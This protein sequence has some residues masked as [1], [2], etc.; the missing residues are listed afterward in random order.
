MV[1]QTRKEMTR[2]VGK[3]YTLGVEQ[4]LRLRPAVCGMN[5]SKQDVFVI[6]QTKLT[7]KNFFHFDD[8]FTGF[9]YFF[10]RR[11]NPGPFLK[12]HFIGK[13][14]SLAGIMLNVDIMP[15]IYK[16]ADVGRDDCNTVFVFFPLFGQTNFHSVLVLSQHIYAGRQMKNCLTL[17]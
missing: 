12:V 3:R 13:P 10:L 6:Q 2:R 11:E 17:L 7:R 15:G 4:L 14:C 8:Q 16:P 1:E 9:E 5:V